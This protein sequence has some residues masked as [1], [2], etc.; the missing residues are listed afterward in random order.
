[1]SIEVG[2]PKGS[3][4]K[5][6]GRCEKCPLGTYQN[7]TNSLKC[8]ECPTNT[9]TTKIGA[10]DISQCLS[11]YNYIHSFV[12]I[13]EPNVLT[14]KKDQYKNQNLNKAIFYKR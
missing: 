13:A 7:L 12:K 5:T 2:C 10:E 6:N 8:E 1:L 4:A 3:F 11:M 14:L 9:N